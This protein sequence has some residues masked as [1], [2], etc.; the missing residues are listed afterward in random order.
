MNEDKDLDTWCS[1]KFTNKYM[2]IED[3]HP[4]SY[5]LKE[6]RLASFMQRTIF[7]KPLDKY[8]LN[9]C[10]VPGV[11]KLFVSVDGTF[12][13]CEKISSKAPPIGNV[14]SGIDIETIKKVYIEEYEKI[15]LPVCSKCW[16]IRFCNICYIQVFE[17]GK[18]DE[19]RK[20]KACRV[21]LFSKNRLLEFVTTLMERDPKGLDYLYDVI[22][23]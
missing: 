14:F 5:N 19:K 6:K 16:A 1:E 23:E 12:L 3:D 13:V 20:L 18:L 15:S 17:E 7:D 9:G 10:C 8:H 21:E 22:L 11:R 4:I 2:G